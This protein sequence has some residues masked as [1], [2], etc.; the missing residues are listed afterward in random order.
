M[1]KIISFFLLLS[2]VACNAQLSGL[3]NVP[4]TPAPVGLTGSNAVPPGSVLNN[5]TIN[6]ANIIEDS[7]MMILSSF[8]NGDLS[9]IS[10]RNYYSADGIYF[11][12]IGPLPIA[13]VD[14][15][16]GYRLRDPR[17]YLKSNIW[18]ITSLLKFN[19]NHS[20][21]YS[22]TNFANWQSNSTITCFSSGTVWDTQF[23]DDPSSGSTFLL[24]SRST[25]GS[26]GFQIYVKQV[27]NWSI[28]PTD[29]SFD[30][31][32]MLTNS[33]G[34][35]IWTNMI[36][37]SIVNWNGT[38]NLFFK[39]EDQ[40]TDAN[41]YIALA[42]STGSIY[43]PYDMV[44][45]N[46][47]LG[48][49][50]G[51]EGNS[52]VIW[53]NK[54]RLYFDRNGTTNTL[55][56]NSVFVECDTNAFPLG[57]WTNLTQLQCQ[58]YLSNPGAMVLSNTVKQL[59]VSKAI[60]TKSLGDQP[61]RVQYNNDYSVFLGANILAG[62]LGFPP[63]W[64]RMSLVDTNKVG[65][66]FWESINDNTFYFV[67][68]SAPSAGATVAPFKVTSSGGVGTIVGTT[69]TANSLTT[70]NAIFYN[71]LTAPTPAS[72]GANGGQ[73]WKSNTVLYWS[74]TADGSTSNNAV[75]IAP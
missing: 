59:L 1:N 72:L 42:Q 63:A 21:V 65:L 25:N 15:G 5:I 35:S 66:S 46:N 13:S 61:M 28:F 33:T 45:S 17:F 32:V 20:V 74:Y 68:Y 48:I 54:W 43:G 11:K 24:F 75:K 60:A 34:G 3:G 2:S 71:K 55:L 51:F 30:S 67:F 56:Q 62:Q 8:N 39:Q 44:R 38:N 22:S 49:G 50:Y 64:N 4:L 27:T 6:D 58:D 57:P 52:P 31:P 9:G 12:P 29:S 23:Y 14:Y 37:P 26:T 7:P 70:S 47:W 69:V 18:Y 40:T 10:L 36:G 73:L 53:N 41:R 19:D 16:S